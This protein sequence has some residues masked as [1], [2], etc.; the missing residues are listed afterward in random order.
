MTIVNFYSILEIDKESDA[1][2][3]RKA[4]R[5]QRRE[6]RNRQA[7]PKAETRAMAEAMTQH[8]SDAE[9]TLLDPAKRSQ[10]DR[11]LAEHVPL[12][13]GPVPEAQGR[14]WVQVAREYMAA[15]HASQAN[16][17]GREATGQQPENSEA[18]YIRGVS[19]RAL[20]N[21]A[22][23]EFELGEAIRLNPKEASFHCELG[24][25]YGAAGQ[26]RRAEQA[27]RRASELDPQNVFFQVGVAY[28]LTAQERPDE[29]LPALKKAVETDPDNDLFKFHYAAALLDSATG[30]WSQFPDE[31]STI[32]NEVQL[33]ATREA[34]ERISAVGV[35]DPELRADVDEV[36]RLAD[37]AERVRW[38]GS[39][40]L[41][42]YVLGMLGAFVAMLVSFGIASGPSGGAA[43]FFGFLFLLA[44]GLIPIAFVKRH[45]MPTWRWEQKQAPAMVRNSGLQP[46]GGQ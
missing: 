17:A 1:D 32:L 29:A 35:Q 28:S 34:L 4:V 24:D 19:S 10:Y 46:I 38:F 27:Y 36:A 13:D 6:W 40:N 9:D 11:Q 5:K 41:L 8:I 42:G 37:R 14:N 43:G 23:A 3:V 33:A 21:L 30:K 2:A 45:R 15:G 22:D 7:H 25:L 12:A 20:N 18:W 16:Y 26:P 31:S 44:L 39:D